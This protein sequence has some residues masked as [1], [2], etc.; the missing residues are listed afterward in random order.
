[1]GLGYQTGSGEG[2]AQQREK[3]IISQ[4]LS[5]R[6]IFRGSLYQFPMAAE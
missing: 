1:M 6:I 3:Y 5:C 4:K 2:K